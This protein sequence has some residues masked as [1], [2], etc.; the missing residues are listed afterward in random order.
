MCS[1]IGLLLLGFG[2]IPPTGLLVLFLIGLAMFVLSLVSAA[3]IKP[4]YLTMVVITF[5][6]GWIISHLVMGLFFYVIITPI[7]IL[8]KITGRDHLCR[9]F[10][11]QADTYWIPYKYK[12]SAK[13]YFHQF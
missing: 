6:I 12:R 10:D 4:V 7:A 8:F 5:T 3:L 9:K 2:K 1:V 13:D 11:P